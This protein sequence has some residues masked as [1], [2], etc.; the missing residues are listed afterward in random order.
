MSGELLAIDERQVPTPFVTRSKWRLPVNWNEFEVYGRCNHRDW[1][2]V[3]TRLWAEQDILVNLAYCNAENDRF[4]RLDPRLDARQH[5][6]GLLEKF[7][8]RLEQATI[9]EDM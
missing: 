9:E 8:Q 4:R 2:S 3:N 1:K 6:A 7:D 5:Y